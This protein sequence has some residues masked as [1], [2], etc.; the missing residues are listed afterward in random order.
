M[1]EKMAII[2][3]STLLPAF[4]VGYV[5]RSNGKNINFAVVGATV[6]Y[7]V[8]VVLI[9]VSFYL[10]AA[11]NMKGN[12]LVLMLPLIVAGLFYFLLRGMK[13]GNEK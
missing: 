6:V 2:L 5:L 9:Y 7:V 8:S 11:M 10:A 3:F 13:S 1:D 12:D 4:A